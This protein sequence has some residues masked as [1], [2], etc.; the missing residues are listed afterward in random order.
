MNSVPPKVDD[1]PKSWNVTLF[2]SKAFADIIK[3]RIETRVY[4]LRVGPK[5]PIMRMSL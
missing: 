5:V 1:D 2:V 4:W 3:T